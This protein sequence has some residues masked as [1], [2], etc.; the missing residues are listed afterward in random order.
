[1]EREAKAQ[2]F[3]CPPPSGQNDVGQMAKMCGRMMGRRFSPLALVVAGVLLIAVGALI[4]VEPAILAWL[5]A[6]GSV[7]MGLMLL[8]MAGFVRRMRTGPRE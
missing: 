1:M 5:L 2:G 6:A 7:L 8:T 3:G 4:V